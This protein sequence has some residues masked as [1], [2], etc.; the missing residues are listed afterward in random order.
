MSDRSSPNPEGRG[1]A[2]TLRAIARGENVST[3][4]RTPQGFTITQDQLEL[5]GMRAQLNDREQ[6]NVINT[7]EYNHYSVAEETRRM[8]GGNRSIQSV[9]ARGELHT[10]RFDVEALA[11]L[12]SREGDTTYSL[13]GYGE[14]RVE[15]EVHRPGQLATFDITQQAAARWLT[16]AGIR[17]T[18]EDIATD[19]EVDRFEQQT[20][21]GMIDR[22]KDIAKVR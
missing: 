12:K 10:T 16:A 17:R 21:R 15:L 7:P 3:T 6:E 19:G 11:T 2:A 1:L 9:H 14:G 8:P 18:Q 20:I 13:R 22:A 4:A 5:E